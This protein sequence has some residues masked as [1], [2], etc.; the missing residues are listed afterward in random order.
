MSGK[1]KEMRSYRKKNKQKKKEKQ[2]GHA[3]G[4]R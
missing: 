4:R 1:T 3:D 2:A